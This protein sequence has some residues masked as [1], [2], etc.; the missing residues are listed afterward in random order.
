M[1]S[2]HADFVLREHGRGRFEQGQAT[3][4]Q[5]CFDPTQTGSGREPPELRPN[6]LAG[7]ALITPAPPSQA[8]AKSHHTRP[9][10][11]LLEKIISGTLSISAD[12]VRRYVA[13]PTR[14]AQAKETSRCA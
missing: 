5:S 14:R 10:R 3:V 12:T 8:L 4:L 11:R 6:R 13:R 1:A 7:F 2:V 9:A